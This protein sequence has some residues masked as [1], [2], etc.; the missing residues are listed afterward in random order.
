MKRELKFRA[1]D[2]KS[3]SFVEISGHKQAVRLTDEGFE[4]STGYDGLDNPTFGMDDQDGY[5]KMTWQEYKD[6]Q[7]RFTYLQFTGL[8]D[9]N[10]KEIY[11]GDILEGVSNNVF[12]TGEKNNYEVMWGIDHW[13][14]NGTHFSLQ[15]LFGYCNKNITVIGNIF[16]NPKINRK[17]S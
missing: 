9:K 3:N 14:I 16:D 5:S 8:K 15:E 10:G 6:Y 17:R 7:E 2:K 12:S 4:M 11:E 13:H 1:W